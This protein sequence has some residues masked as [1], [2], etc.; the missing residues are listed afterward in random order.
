MNTKMKMLAVLVL[1]CLVSSAS[2][3]QTIK[4]KGNT[5][6]TSAKSKTV[7]SNRRRTSGNAHSRVNDDYIV[8]DSVAVEVDDEPA[9]TTYLMELSMA[10]GFKLYGRK[11][12]DYVDNADAQKDLAKDLQECKNAKTGCLTNHKGIYVYGGNGYNSNGLNSDM[13]D[14]LSYCNKNKFTVNDVAV[15]DVGWWCV[16][17]ENTLYKGNVP[18]DCKKALDGFAKNNEKILSI[19]ISE[20]GNYAIVTDSHY[21]ASNSFDSKILGQAIERY[22]RIRSVCITN[23]GILVTCANGIYF[24]DVPSNVIDKLQKK[25]GT[26]TL[27]RYTDSGT[28]MAFDGDGFQAFYM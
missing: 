19:S 27:V 17:Y 2:A 6:S 21:E 20:N 25:N 4:R 23:R 16:V 28:Y 7:T 8:E 13:K 10:S 26:P 5:S 12:A 3:Q 18:E 22:G 15:T 11:Y 1:S 14:A 9:G 24:W